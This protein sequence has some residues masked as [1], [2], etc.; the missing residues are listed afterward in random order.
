[1]DEELFRLAERGE[2][3]N[4]EVLVAQSM[5]LLRDPRSEALVENFATQWLTLRTLRS[6][7]PDPKRFPSFNE[8]LREAMLTETKLF[9]ASIMRENRSILDLL[10]GKYTFLNEL[11]AKHYGIPYVNGPN[12]RRVTL[13]GEQRGGILTH[14]SILTVT[15]NPTR[16]SPVKRGKWV[17][18]QLLGTPPPPPPPNVPELKP[19]EGMMLTGTLRQKMEQHRT[20]PMC[21]SCH[22]QMDAIGFGLENYD[23]VGAWRSAEGQFPVDASGTLPGGKSFRGPME[24]IRILKDRK[25]DFARSFSERLL[26]YAIGRGLQ[27]NDRCEVRELSGRV[28]VG[29]YRFQTL[30]AEIVKSE[31]FRMRKGEGAGG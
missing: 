22:A 10:D 19:D 8:P 14:A 1:P 20:N 2:L 27:Y 18:E 16:T 25:Q 31:P 26:T 9:F 23:A 17:L 24:L 6:F 5:R 29:G 7:S 28:A 15:S 11:L 21:A 30:I 13:S 12:F 3:Q 4:P